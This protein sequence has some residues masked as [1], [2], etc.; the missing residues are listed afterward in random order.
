MANEPPNRVDI[1]REF[2]VKARE[3][4]KGAIHDWALSVGHGDMTVRQ[5]KDLADRVAELVT[6]GFAEGYQIGTEPHYK[7]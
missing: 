5:V 2:L 7:D 1:R 6:A 3:N 4:A